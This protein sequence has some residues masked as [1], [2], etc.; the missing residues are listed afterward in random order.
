MPEEIQTFAAD[1]TRTEGCQ[2]AVKAAA[3][4]VTIRGLFNCAGLELH[5]TVETMPEVDYDL[6]MG[7]NLRAV[8]MMCKFAVPAM[9]EAG[10][11]AIVNMSSIQ[12]LATQSGVAA[13]AA[14]KGAVI[15]LTRVMALD[16]GPQN[17]RVNAICPGTIAT[18][19]VKANAKHFRPEDPGGSARRMG[20]QARDRQDR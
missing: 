13:Y 18:P 4:S 2:A 20:Q 6:V 3:G 17:I 5:G 15:S 10:G 1:L 19:L 12:A 16:H 9:V 7:V 14:S 8:F 11:G